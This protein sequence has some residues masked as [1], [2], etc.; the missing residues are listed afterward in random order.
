VGEE[1]PPQPA[2]EH[3]FAVLAKAHGLIEQGEET[4]TRCRTQ[5]CSASVQGRVRANDNQEDTE[6]RIGII[7]LKRGPSQGFCKD[8]N[9][10]LHP[11]EGGKSLD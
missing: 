10:F 11:I 4:D 5:F 2:I 9:G 3:L 1:L 8:C 6:D 7:R